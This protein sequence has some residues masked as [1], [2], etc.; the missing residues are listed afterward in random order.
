MKN[1]R[2][3]TND[4]GVNY[5]LAENMLGALTTFARL[6]SVSME[7]PDTTSIKIEEA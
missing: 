4:H 1:Y 7:N 6:A 3:T 2:V 5:V